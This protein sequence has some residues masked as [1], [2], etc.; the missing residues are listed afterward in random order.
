MWQGVAFLPTLLLG[1]V[2][3][4]CFWLLIA[5]VTFWVTRMDDIVD[6]FEGIYSAGRY[7][8]TAY[9]SW[10]R[11]CLTF[12]VPVAFAVTVPAEAITGRLTAQTLL[13]AMGLA[14]LALAVS[15]TVWLQGLRRYSGAS[16]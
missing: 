7:P 6:C 13:G 11:V 8:V 4:Y 9:P 12:V 2:L 15:R 5:S 14:A 10:M 3:I 16:S 1:A